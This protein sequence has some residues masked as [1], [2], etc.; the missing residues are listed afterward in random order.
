MTCWEIATE[1]VGNMRT[2]SKENMDVNDAS[3][4]QLQQISFASVFCGGK[5]IQRI[6]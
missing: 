4:K 1:K 6:C 3:F 2:K 5:C